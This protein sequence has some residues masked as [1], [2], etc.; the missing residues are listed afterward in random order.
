VG[1]LFF[2]KKHPHKTQKPSLKTLGSHL[3]TEILSEDRFNQ[4]EQGINEQKQRN[5]EIERIAVG[6]QPF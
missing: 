4:K 5:D 2:S 1:G 6:K 3:Q